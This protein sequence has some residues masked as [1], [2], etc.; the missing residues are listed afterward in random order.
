MFGYIKPFKPELK[1]RDFESYKAVYC[2]LCGQLGKSFGPLARITLS[3]DFTFLSMLGFAL[4]DES[5]KFSPCRCYVNP[6]RK[7]PCAGESEQLRLG[8]DIAAITLYYKL[9]DNIADSGLL[10]KGIWNILRP[11]A[12]SARKKAAQRQ[13]EIDR[14]VGESMRQQ[15]EIESLKTA[16]LDKACEPTANAMAGIFETLSSDEKLRRVLFRFGYFIG[17]FIYTCDALDD[18]GCDLKK[19]GYNPLILKFGIN[20]VDKSGIETP[21]LHDAREYARES[22]YMTVGEAAKAYELLPLSGFKPVLDNIISLGLRASVDEI[23]IKHSD[24]QV[25]D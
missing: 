24:K 6:L 20:P 2:G 10:G 13:P 1:I 25:T 16:S 22:L 5:A 4:S 3:Y 11:F 18:L 23:M 14:I 8:A 9:M 15:A 21:A 12:L 19:G 17:R 7:V